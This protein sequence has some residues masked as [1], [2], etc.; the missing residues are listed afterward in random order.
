MSIKTVEL[1]RDLLPGRQQLTIGEVT[2]H[3]SRNTVRR[4]L[5][6]DVFGTESTNRTP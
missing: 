4:I 1:N 6:L 3:V 2:F 5:P